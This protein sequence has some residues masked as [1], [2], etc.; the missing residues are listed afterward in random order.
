LCDVVVD[1]DDGDDYRQP[2]ENAESEDEDDTKHQ[3][4]HGM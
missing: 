4:E 2:V 1:D 3:I